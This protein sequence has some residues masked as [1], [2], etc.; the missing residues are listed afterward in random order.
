MFAIAIVVLF[1]L[2]L[3][4]A[5]YRYRVQERRAELRTMKRHAADYEESHK[6]AW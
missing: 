3:G 1:L 6:G 4:I 2:W 5:V